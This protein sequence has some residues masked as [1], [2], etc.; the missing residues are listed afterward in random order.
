MLSPTYYPADMR[1]E[2]KLPTTSLEMKSVCSYPYLEEYFKVFPYRD[3]FE[4]ET[5]DDEEL[6]GTFCDEFS[7]AWRNLSKDGNNNYLLGWPRNRQD[8]QFGRCELASLGYAGGSRKI[9]HD[10]R[11]RAEESAHERWQLLLQ[12]DEVILSDNWLIELMLHLSD[13][14]LQFFISKEDLAARRFDRVWFDTQSS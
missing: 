3:N 4:F 1:D 13:G 12:L 11:Q 6:Y 7:A 9:P 10:V 8:S 14:L 2:D 5:D